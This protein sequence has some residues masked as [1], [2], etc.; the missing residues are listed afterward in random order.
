MKTFII[1]NSP[2]QQSYINAKSCEESFQQHAGWEVELFDGC[3]PSTINDYQAAYKLS[4]KRATNKSLSKKSC[5]YSHYKL[6]KHSAEND[7]PVAIIENDT[8]CLSGCPAIPE[9]GVYHLSIETNIKVNAHGRNC[10][11][12]SA[13]IAQKPAGIHSVK[14]LS[15]RNLQT[16]QKCMPG[17]TAYIITPKSAEALIRDCELKGWYQNDSLITTEL[18]NLNYIIPSPIKYCEKKELKTSSKWKT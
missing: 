9:E 10:K 17:S 4:D 3:N 5:F 13:L 18:V 8:E 1:Y 6:W 12:D 2:I 14:E 16:R 7:I 11:S 15:Q